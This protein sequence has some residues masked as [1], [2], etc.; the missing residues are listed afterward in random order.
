LWRTFESAA[1]S[2]VYFVISFTFLVAGM[3]F[4]MHENQD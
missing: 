3:G 1:E 4:P 2:D